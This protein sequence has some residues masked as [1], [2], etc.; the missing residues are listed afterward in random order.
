MLSIKIKL[1][2]GSDMDR[3]ESLDRMGRKSSLRYSDSCIPGRG[4]L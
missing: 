4:E 2:Y 3:G 1:G